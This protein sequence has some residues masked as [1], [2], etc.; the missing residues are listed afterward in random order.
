MVQWSRIPRNSC[1][2]SQGTA[3]KMQMAVARAIFCE[4][5]ACTVRVVCHVR[6]RRLQRS[7]RPKTNGVGEKTIIFGCLDVFF[8][9]ILM[10]CS[11][12]FDVFFGGCVHDVLLSKIQ[13]NKQYKNE[14]GHPVHLVHNW[15]LW[16]FWSYMYILGTIVTS[17]ASFQGIPWVHRNMRLGHQTSEMVDDF[18]IQL[19]LS[20]K[21]LPVETWPLNWLNCASWVCHFDTNIAEGPWTPSLWPLRIR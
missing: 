13:V 21:I 5:E 19:H 18:C 6:L 17:R 15:F 9:A 11:C 8:D 16:T 20:S 14:S 2:F 12:F 3:A 4:A 10:C 1:C 7:K